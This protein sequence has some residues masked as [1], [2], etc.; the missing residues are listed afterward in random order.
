MSW[1]LWDFMQFLQDFAQFSWDFMCSLSSKLGSRGH[2]APSMGTTGF[3]ANKVLLLHYTSFLPPSAWQN[4]T[5]II[6]TVTQWEL[7]YLIL[8][9]FLVVK[10]FKYKPWK[11]QLGLKVNWPLVIGKS[12][13]SAFSF[14]HLSKRIDTMYTCNFYTIFKGSPMQAADVECYF[15]GS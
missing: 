5:I 8:Y 12:A 3:K 14:W 4:V 6:A 1:F 9:A 15:V 11:L 10:G 7:E 13:K 2:A